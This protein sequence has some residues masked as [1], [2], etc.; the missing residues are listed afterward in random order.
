MLLQRCTFTFTICNII[1]TAF[2]SF[3]FFVSFV[4]SWPLAK[5]YCRIR[6]ILLFRRH[7]EASTYLAGCELFSF[8]AQVFVARCIAL[9]EVPTA[10]GNQR[11]VYH[12]TGDIQGEAFALL[13]EEV[14]YYYDDYW[15]G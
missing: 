2:V 5:V 3:C 13:R 4:L 9:I 12:C 10:A 14:S 11:E 6:L 8:A 7:H 1:M 15:W